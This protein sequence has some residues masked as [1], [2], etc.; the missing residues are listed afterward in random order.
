M[1]AAHPFVAFVGCRFKRI[2]CVRR[3]KVKLQEEDLADQRAYLVSVHNNHMEH[4]LSYM[5]SCGE[6][7]CSYSAQ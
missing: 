4:H 7:H 2:G 3:I 6:R 1:A 5:G